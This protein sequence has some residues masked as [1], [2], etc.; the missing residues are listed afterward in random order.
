MD[1]NKEELKPLE[2]QT[3]LMRTTFGEF[4]AAIVLYLPFAV[5][6]SIFTRD[7]SYYSPCDTK[8]STYVWSQ[9]SSI[10]L[11]VSCAFLGVGS[12]CFA[13]TTLKLKDNN[14]ALALC[15][16]NITALM[17][18]VL[19]V[20]SLV[21]YGGLC[22]AYGENEKC[23]HLNNLIIG[24]IIVYSITLGIAVICLCL[25]CCF[26]CCMIGGA[27]LTQQNKEELN[28]SGQQGLNPNTEKNEV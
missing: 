7:E 8:S 12:P 2:N 20:V 19:A 9:F 16:Q 25:A 27:M 18:F 10:F 11:I 26:G 24:Y 21:N 13:C 15:F 17:K 14:A 3:N 5:C 6:F 4:C 23:G 28:S 1:K 22:Y